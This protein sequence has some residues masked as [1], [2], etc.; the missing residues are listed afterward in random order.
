MADTLTVTTQADRDF[1]DEK[2]PGL[3]KL[4]K[5]AANKRNCEARRDKAIADIVTIDAAIA[6]ESVKI[7]RAFDR[8]NATM[9]AT[10]PASL[11][12]QAIDRDT[13]NETTVHWNA[14][15]AVYRD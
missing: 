14:Q 1:V 13:A 10:L 9:G 11:T 5:L 8:Y 15:A 7:K 6:A 2:E 12:D 3:V 4:E